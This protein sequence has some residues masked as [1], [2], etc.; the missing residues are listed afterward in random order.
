[1]EQRI[2]F[3]SIKFFLNL[4]KKNNLKIKLE[5]GEIHS[6][7]DNSSGE[8]GI[9]NIHSSLKSTKIKKINFFNKNRKIVDVESANAH[10][11]AISE[12]GDVFGWGWNLYGQISS[13]HKNKFI[14][15]KIFSIDLKKFKFNK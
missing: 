12:D 9:G 7:G 14:P 11:I 3:I 1:L 13:D 2:Y 6:V 10:S 8:L 4:N 5:N 15:E